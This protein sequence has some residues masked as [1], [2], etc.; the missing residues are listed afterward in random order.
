MFEN[1]MKEVINLHNKGNSIVFYSNTHTFHRII[2]NFIKESFVKYTNNYE[3]LYVLDKNQEFKDLALRNYLSVEEFLGDR[4]VIQA[5]FS[6]LILNENHKTLL[7]N[8]LETDEF[9]NYCLSLL[10]YNTLILISNL[11]KNEI[12]T[13]EGLAEKSNK[14][15]YLVEI[16]IKDGILNIGNI[17]LFEDAKNQLNLN[18]N[19]SV[20]NYEENNILNLNKSEEYVSKII[21]NPILK[22]NDEF[23]TYP[24]NISISLL[25]KI[26]EYSFEHNLP[27]LNFSN[28]DKNHYV[29]YDINEDLKHL[30]DKQNN[31]YLLEKSKLKEYLIYIV[32]YDHLPKF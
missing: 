32:L 14:K 17:E 2:V 3:K 4:V 25:N 24:I 11:D 9:Y 22:T 20:N 19:N 13:K 28:H 5:M 15:L 8:D 29:F 6:N 31:I 16:L 23:K 1:K 26:F 18:L 7:L 27:N 21:H 12:L 30:F 10:K